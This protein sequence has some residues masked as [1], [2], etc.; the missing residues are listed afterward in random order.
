MYA[1]FVDK[2]IGVDYIIHMSKLVCMCV[3]ETLLLEGN[4]KY[5]RGISTCVYV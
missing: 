2:C 5:V 4:N 3:P 1:L